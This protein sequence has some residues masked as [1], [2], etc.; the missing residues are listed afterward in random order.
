MNS[1]RL[2]LSPIAAKAVT[3][4]NTN[5]TDT[6]VTTGG[7]YIESGVNANVTLDGVN[8]QRTGNDLFA[9]KIADNIIQGNYFKVK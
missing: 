1:T 8:I 4:K 7:I 3:I 9:F 2:V 5:G 6:A